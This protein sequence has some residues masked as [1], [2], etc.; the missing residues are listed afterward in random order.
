MKGGEWVYATH[1][2]ADSK[3]VLSRIQERMVTGLLTAPPTLAA[4]HPNPQL[5]QVFADLLLVGASAHLLLLQPRNKCL[6]VQP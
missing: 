6:L 3:E 4:C 1:D 5:Q 2:L